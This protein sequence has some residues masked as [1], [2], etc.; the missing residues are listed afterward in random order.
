MHDI[1]KYSSWVTIEPEKRGWSND[2]KF[3]ITD[4]HG[5]ELLLRLADISQHDKKQQEF[6][7]MQKAAATGIPMSQPLEFGICE[8]GRSVYTLL[9]WI[10]GAEAE[11]VIKGYT[12]KQCY[13]LGIKAGKFLRRIHSIPSPPSNDTYC[14]MRQ[15]YE[16]KL[17][18]YHECGMQVTGAGDFLSYIDAA[19]SLLVGL[20]GSY[21][22]G[23]YHV[24][25]MIITPDNELAI[26]DFNRFKF[27]DYIR[28]FN[29]LAVFS[30]QISTDF[31]RGQ[32]DGYF[33]G[34]IA[35]EFFPR[36]AFY[37]AF[38]NFFSV[39]WAMPFGDDEVK[40]T[41]ARTE[42]VRQDFKGFTTCIPTWY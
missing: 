40:A 5:N 31:A 18:R 26:I 34:Q 2:R 20:P 39:L 10:P 42:M 7:W 37:A 41:L 24:G 11:E 29:R 27:G 32:I 28:D 1:P 4:N 25:N 13:D 12:P 36:L 3:H 14:S 6:L 9:N 35:D 33:D 8:N 21:L 30:R 22:H 23:D 15:V 38:D 19:F 16:Q 17:R